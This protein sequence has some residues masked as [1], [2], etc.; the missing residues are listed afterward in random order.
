[1]DKRLRDLTRSLRA[2]GSE[3]AATWLL[4]HYPNRTFGAGLAI[5][6]IAHLSWKRADQIRL[7]THYLSNLPHASDVA[8]RAFTSFMA[9]PRFLRVIEGHLPVA[10]DREDLLFY[11]LIPTLRDAARTD[12]DRDAIAR[13]LKRHWRP[14]DWS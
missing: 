4:D 9:V 12:A 14:Q 13:F 1:M 8:Y 6:A 2:M 11:Y 5:S 7:A 10:E 3:Q